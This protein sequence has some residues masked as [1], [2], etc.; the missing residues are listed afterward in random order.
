MLLILSITAGGETAES[1]HGTPGEVLQELAD[2][3]GIPVDGAQFRDIIT[4][5]AELTAWAEIELVDEGRRYPVSLAE[6]D[7]AAAS[8][9]AALELVRKKR[10]RSSM[11]PGA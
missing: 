10:A 11:A 2:T 3:I 5:A 9:H 6:L 1:A 7:H 8:H 4:G